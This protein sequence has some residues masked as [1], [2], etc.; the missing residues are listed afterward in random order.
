MLNS[1]NMKYKW[2][3]II[4]LVVLSNMNLRHQTKKDT[5]ICSRESKL[6]LIILSIWSI[7]IFLPVEFMDLPPK[8]P[9]ILILPFMSLLLKNLLTSWWNKIINLLL[10]IYSTLLLRWKFKKD[11]LYK[12]QGIDLK[13]FKWEKFNLINSKKMIYLTLLMLILG[14]WA[15]IEEEQ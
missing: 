11:N 13:I 7:K 3:L 8:D 6:E 1:E 15:L 5:T 12:Y 4:L 14:I 2:D 10:K 9:L